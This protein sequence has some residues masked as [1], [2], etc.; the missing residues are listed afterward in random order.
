MWAQW[1]AERRDERSASRVPFALVAPTA[2]A[3]VHPSTRVIR[4]ERPAARLPPGVPS[5]PRAQSSLRLAVVGS[6]ALA[7][8][9]GCSHRPPT[10]ETAATQ[11]TA[12]S[13]P[14]AVAVASAQPTASASADAPPPPACGAGTL[15]VPGGVFWMG[16]DGV[17]EE[18][19]RHR[20]AVR[21]FCLDRTE[22]TVEAYGA[23]VEAGSCSP[24]HG[25]VAFCNAGRGD[26]GDH[27]VNCVDWNQ[28]HAACAAWGKRL[29]T[30]REWE[31]AARGGA[32]QRAFP[33]GPEP[34]DGRACYQQGSTCKV[35]SYP[36]GAF[37][38]VDMGGNV[39]EWTSSHFGSYPDEAE[40]GWLRVYR[41]GS[42]SRRFP[43]WLRNGLRNRYR[44]AE[45]GAHLGFRCA[46]DLRDAPCPAGSA[47]GAKGCAVEAD[48]APS[49]EA[50][51]A[52]A[53]RATAAHAGSAEAPGADAAMPT[54]PDERRA[55]TGAAPTRERDPRF[56]HDCSRWNPTRPVAY[57]LR[58]GT[59]AQRQSLKGACTN[60]DVEV[61]FN[62]VCCKE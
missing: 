27:P 12:S 39:W 26:R 43:K 10:E 14:T 3:Y 46:G 28:A 53:P 50:M 23:C 33:W 1:R 54:T 40:T 5:L 29:P 55:A 22:V 47:E 9:G 31:Y 36:A 49:P 34:P 48:A 59:F 35:G 25:G 18:S 30:E 21:S 57:A 45:F 13:A 61:G 7:A 17:G 62:S 52:P 37:G 2:T 41:G 4:R 20:V 56:D 42:F 51:R 15:L 58:G 44:E 16:S 6:V 11:A 60:R 24:P 19:P 8:W 38:L 32:E